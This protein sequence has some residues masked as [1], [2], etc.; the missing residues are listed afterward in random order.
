MSPEKPI[1][2]ENKMRPRWGLIWIPFAVLAVLPLVAVILDPKVNQEP[3][4]GLNPE[5]NTPYTPEEKAIIL[6]ELKRMDAENAEQYEKDARANAAR[7]ATDTA[8]AAANAKI[9]EAER[10]PKAE[11]AIQAQFSV[12][13]HWHDLRL[14]EDK[15]DI[16][17]YLGKSDFQSIP[18][19]DREDFIRS[20]GKVWC[21]SMPGGAFPSLEIYDIRTGAK[22]GGYGCTLGN[23]SMPSE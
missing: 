9:L 16:N 6:K 22:L 10:I 15:G 14:K 7:V 5:T 13:T 3:E 19:P 8:R 4:L 20:V 17:I 11:A 12:Y 18:F 21:D 1:S 23:V 2:G